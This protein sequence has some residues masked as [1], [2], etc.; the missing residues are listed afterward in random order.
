MVNLYKCAISQCEMFSDAFPTTEVFNG[1]GFAVRSS[2]VDKAALKFDMGDADEVED[3]DERVND[4]IDGFKYN[5]ISFKKAEFTG[6]IKGYIK[7]VMDRVKA[8]GASE[9]EV[10]EF[11][12]NSTEMVKFILGRFDDFEFYA[13]E[14]N[15]MEGA[16]AMGYWADEEN[17]KG[18]TFL[19]F[20]DGMIRE[21]I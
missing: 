4:I 19:Y 8:R 7:A 6:Y 11:Q 17:D 20:K 15:D 18:P 2:I 3:Q 14:L 5:A 16:V 9:E 21:K 13:N 10:K 12:K 1:A